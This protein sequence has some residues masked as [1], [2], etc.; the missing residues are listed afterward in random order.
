MFLAM[1]LRGITVHFGWSAM[2]QSHDP[3]MGLGYRSERIREVNVV[4]QISVSPVV[5]HTNAICS[6]NIQQF[7]LNISYT[8][9]FFRTTTTVHNLLSMKKVLEA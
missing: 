8:R 7:F 2:F 3:P 5:P 6:M 1:Q 9:T 4:A